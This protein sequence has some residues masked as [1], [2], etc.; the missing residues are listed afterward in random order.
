MAHLSALFFLA[1]EKSRYLIPKA[2]QFFCWTVIHRLPIWD[3]VH[4]ENFFLVP[5]VIDIVGNQNFNIF[6]F[7]IILMSFSW[8]L[9]FFLETSLYEFDHPHY[10]HRHHRHHH[11]CWCWLEIFHFIHSNL[12]LILIIIISLVTLYSIL[13]LYRC[14]CGTHI[15]VVIGGDKKTPYYNRKGV[16]SFNVIA[17]FDFDLLFT[18]F[19]AR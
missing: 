9:L 2:L 13:G 14:H 12:L 7:L 6:I 17:A 8:R 5:D 1:P 16:T 11:S 19:M 15:Q 10:H 4:A 18:Y 3:I